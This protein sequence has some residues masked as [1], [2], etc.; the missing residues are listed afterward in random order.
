MSKHPA[1]CRLPT[2]GSPA[3]CG[4][5]TPQRSVINVIAARGRPHL[6][7]VGRLVPPRYSGGHQRSGPSEAAIRA[8]VPNSEVGH[9]R[10][11]GGHPRFQE[12]MP[13][14]HPRGCTERVPAKLFVRQGRLFPAQGE[15]LRKSVTGSSGLGEVGGIPP[16][17]G[18]WGVGSGVEA[19]KD[20]KP[21]H[22]GS[23][24][25]HSA[26]RVRSCWV[27]FGDW[28]NG[29]TADSGSA[30]LGSNPRSPVFPLNVG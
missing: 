15:T 24:G 29:S 8:C 22:F 13:A 16:G 10:L 21:R 1:I 28:C 17:K 4:M 7:V 26:R 27:F 3:G 9:C 25:Y 19:R 2:V 5:H 20:I 18:Q 30:S 23:R 11:G 14:M 12:P 6:Q